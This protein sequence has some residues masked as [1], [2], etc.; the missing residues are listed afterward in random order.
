MTPELA[1]VIGVNIGDGGVYSYSWGRS[2]RS[3]IV[4]FTASH[5]E[6]WYYRDFVKPT[7][8]SSFSLSGR[9]YLRSDNTTRLVI[10]SKKLV[11]FLVGLGLPVGKKTDASIP[12]LIL[13]KKNLIIPF[14][15]GLYH[16]EGS[17]Y[18]R[19]SKMYNRMRRVYNNLW[20]L[21][22][23]MK[24]KT[25]MNQLRHEVVKLGIRPNRLTEKEGVYT[26]R[27]TSQKEIR[28]FLETIKPKYKLQPRSKTL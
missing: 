4:A 15:R 6:Y 13:E 17:I 9:L 7:I 20:T 10:G 8:D 3:H 14:I 21:Q 24:L 1:E 25:L 28:R 16:A 5:E 27:I 11:H 26:L 12:R 2:N 19:Y 18:R 22:V 23:R